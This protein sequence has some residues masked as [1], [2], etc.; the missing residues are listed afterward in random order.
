[1]TVDTMTQ[2]PVGPTGV[3]TLVAKG[4]PSRF[5]SIVLVLTLI[6]TLATFLILANLTPIVPN[7]NVVVTTL[8][9]NAALGVIL[10]VLIVWQG[11]A[12]IRARQKGLAGA[13]L[14]QRVIL[15]FAIVAITPA[16][17]LAAVAV[18]TLDRG[19]DQWFSVRARAIVDN[20]LVVSRAYLEEQARTIRGETLAMASD[21]NRAR[22]LFDTERERFKEL[23][24]VQSTIRG[25]QA[26]YLLNRDMTVV[27]RAANDGG[28]PVPM[29]PPS[30]F[31]QATESEPALLSP[32]SKNLIGSVFRLEGYDDL[33]IFAVRA[34]DPRA[35]QYLRQ[36]EAAAAE[37]TQLERRRFGVQ[38]AFGLMYLIVGLTLLLAA[39]WLG[40]AFANRLVSPIRQLMAAADQVSAGNLYVQV[41]A[42]RKE[43]DLGGLSETFNRMTAQL[44]TQRNA[45]LE[46]S[47][48]IDERRRFTEAVLSG[49]NAGVMGL[50]GDGRV[51]L[52]NRMA[53]TL[54]GSSEAELLNRPLGDVAPELVEL[55][56]EVVSSGARLLQSTVTLHRNGRERTVNARVTSERSVEAEHGYVVTLDDITDLVTAQ[57]TS[58]WGD[59]ARR[60]AHEI[61][62]PLTPIQLAAERI[63]RKYGKHITEDREVFD[64]C[65]D[66]IV[67]QV[68]DI[69]RMVDEFSSFARMP[70][71]MMEPE[72]VSKTV[73]QV[74]VMMRVGNP[75]IDIA[76]NVPEQPLVAPMD[77]RLLSQAVTNIVKN[78]AES[79]TGVPEEERGPGE[80]VVD[81][82][83]AGGRIIID[84]T[85]NGPGLPAENRS[86]LLEPYMTTREKGTGLGLAIV[87]KILEEHGG[88]IDL[89]DAPAVAEGGQGARVRL[90][91]PA[92]P[93][94]T[95]HEQ[96][97]TEA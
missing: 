50:T 83:N 17:L 65:T 8:C 56:G 62:N 32:G 78:A 15:L 33:W 90:W 51:T 26:V 28:R 60:I 58:A 66:T 70:K 68:D 1:M 42:G 18:I 38:V 61:K 85:D 3:Q 36:T 41:P 64:Q 29:P 43:G 22:P 88:G 75:E 2:E 96:A 10:L 23:V 16:L 94:A 6:S 13:Q 21:L 84:V 48:Q 31:D 69:K 72:D 89:E 9:L 47:E 63:R 14:H 27:E 30:A 93:P 34:V 35:T 82:R 20:A 19:L 87:T 11:W 25:M 24:T 57:R 80:I 71:P 46:A 12:L 39:I 5:G 73:E 76:L 52:V 40:M 54:L 95:T 92:P 67:R 55:F 79:I 37:Y 86:R 45:L 7:H 97:G 59:V 53:E 49:V 4:G 74:V 44:R 77:R 81:V 91:F